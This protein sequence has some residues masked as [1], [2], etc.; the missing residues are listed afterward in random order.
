M[1][2]YP[3]TDLEAVVIEAAMEWMEAKE[4][5]KYGPNHRQLTNCLNALDQACCDLAAECGDVK[6]RN[7]HE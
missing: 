2:S 3:M 5:N 1:T 7:P 4:G 6:W